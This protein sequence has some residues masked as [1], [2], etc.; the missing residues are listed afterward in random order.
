M[1]KSNHLFDAI[2]EPTK[3]SPELFLISQNNQSNC[4]SI[5]SKGY[6]TRRKSGGS[7]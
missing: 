2:F 6:E 4:E 5:D 1:S 3:Q 7:S